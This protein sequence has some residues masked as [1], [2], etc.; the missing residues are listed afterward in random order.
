VVKI[1]WGVFFM[2]YFLLNGTFFLFHWQQEK[3]IKHTDFFKEVLLIGLFGCPIFLWA[4][5]E[6]IKDEWKKSRRYK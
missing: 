3:E 1:G 6:E 5:A 2:I 4:V